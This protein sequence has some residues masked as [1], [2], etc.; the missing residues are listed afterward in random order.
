MACDYSTKFIP[1]INAKAIEYA[2]N[3]AYLKEWFK[4]AFHDGEN[5][6]TRYVSGA[7]F[8]E[9]G[10]SNP[11]RVSNNPY[12]GRFT[13]ETQYDNVSDYYNNA[14][15]LQIKAEQK[16]K[17]EIVKRIIFDI[18]E[19]DAESRWKTPNLIDEETGITE[20]NKSIAKY[21][22]ELCNNLLSECDPESSVEL[23]S[24]LSDSEFTSIIQD[25]LTKYKQYLS[26]NPENA[27]FY[28]DFVTL[29]LFDEMLRTHAPFITPKAEYVNKV[30]NK[31]ISTDSYDK[32]DYHG[33]KVEHYTGYTSSE[34]AAI[35]NQD[36]DLAKL[37]L[38]TIP[39]I[40]E[41]N[42]PI[43][44]SFIG[45]S[46][47][48]ASMTALKNWVLYEAPAEI[49]A[50]Y[51]KGAKADVSKIIDAYLIWNKQLTK[52]IK[53]VY[54]ERSTFLNSKLRS[55]QHY[56]F[57]E[58]SDDL[59]RSMFFGMFFKTEPISYRTYSFNVDTGQ[60]T[61]SNL[62]ST[63]VNAQKFNVEDIVR[64]TAYLTR[65][66][67]T[68]RNNLRAK[69]NV[70]Y[71]KGAMTIS[72]KNDS[73]K[74][75]Q[76]T[77]NKSNN[78]GV[79]GEFLGNASDD[80]KKEVI[81]DFLMFVVPDT[82]RQIG[83]SMESADWDWANDFAPFVGIIAFT[84]EPKISNLAI[85]WGKHNIVDLK[86]YTA[87]TLKVAKKLSVIYGSE[88]R[89]VVKNL[90]GSNLPLYQ[91]T[92]L[93]YNLQSVIDDVI[94]STENSANKSNLL[95]QARELLIAPQVRQEV[96]V[97]NKIKSARELTIKEQL[98]LNV[99]HDFYEAFSSEKDSPAY[100]KVYLQSATYADKSTHYLFGYDLNKDIVVNGEKINL[101][102]II[103]DIINGGSS[104]KLIEITRK[105]RAERI[106]TI[107]SNVL[108]DYNRVYNN[109]F[110][111]IDDVVKFLQTQKYDD[112]KSEF[113]KKGVEFFE[114]IHGTK[115]KYK[116]AP[117]IALNETMMNQYRTYNDSN[118]FKE[119]LDKSKLQFINRID[120]NYWKWNKYDSPIFEKLYGDK[121]F[122]DFIGTNGNI[123]THIGSRLNP[124]LEAY[125][126]TDVL[127]SNEV[128]SLLIGE[129]WAHPNKNKRL[130]LTQEEYNKRKQEDPLFDG[131]VGTYDEFSEANRLIAQIKR[132]VAFGAT[133]HPYIQGLDN[134]VGENIRIAVIED[135][136]GTVFT[137]NG[138]ENFKLDSS[139]GSG[140]AHPL[141][142]RLENN[143][144]IDARVGKNKKSIM[145][146]VDARFGRPTL[147]KWAV[148]ELSNENRRNGILSRANLENVYRKMSDGQF[149]IEPSDLNTWLEDVNLCY[150]DYKTGKYYRIHSFEYLNDDKDD[151]RIVRYK[152]EINPETLE[153]SNVAEQDVIEI[154]T[155]YE[156]DQALGGAWTGE[157]VNG[158]WEYNEAQLDIME[159]MI[160]E[161]YIGKNDFV[162]YL[163]NKSAIKVGSGNV[164]SSNRWNNDE[165]FDTIDMK[166][167]YGGVQMDADHE[168]D[169]AQVTEM[170]QMISAL[171]E[172][173]HYKDLVEN[174][175]R[176]IGGVVA[177]HIAKLD[178]AVKQVLETGSD[179][180][181]LEL[182]KI[183]AKSW[184]GA[185][186]NGN[187]DT[188][189]I[190]QAFV[191]K[192][193]D[194]FRNSD[195]NTRIPF[196]A[197]TINGS[198]VSDVISS[199]NKGGIR[200]K[201]EGY[202]GVLNPSHDM[203]QY[204]KIFRNGRWEVRLFDEFMDWSR[205]Q[206]V[207]FD[208]INDIYDNTLFNTN[209][210]LNPLLKAVNRDQVDFEDT[211]VILDKNGNIV[212]S[213]N[214]LEPQFWYINSFTTYD[215]V[216][217][218]LLRH[219]EYQVYIHTGKPRNLKATNTKFKINGTW[220]SIYDLD[221][222]RAS[223]YLVK[224]IDDFDTLTPERINI[225][226]RAL[227]WRF[228]FDELSQLDDDNRKVAL[229]RLIKRCNN[230]T[231]NI[232]KAIE[233]KQSF[234]A[235]ERFGVSN[236]VTTEDG[237]AIQLNPFTSKLKELGVKKSINVESLLNQLS[238][239]SIIRGHEDI[240]KWVSDFVQGNATL[241]NAPFILPDAIKLRIQKA[242]QINANAVQLINK[243]T[244]FGEDT[245]SEA[246]AARALSLD[247]QNEIIEWICDR[248]FDI[249][250]E[251]NVRKLSNAEQ[252]V[253]LS[254]VADEYNVEA[255]EIIGGRYQF[256]KFGLGENDHIWQI[257]DSGYFYDRLASKY[258]LPEY[259]ESDLFDAILYGNSEQ[260]LVKIGNIPT[261]L[262]GQ[263][264]EST[265]FR[266]V[267]G[268]VY[269]N[270]IK[271]GSSENKKFY[272]YVDETGG[273]HHLILVNT[274]DDLRQIRKSTLFDNVIRYN[275]TPDNMQTLK[276]L[277]FGDDERVK[278][279]I[280]ENQ[281]TF[282]NQN[283]LTL[284]QLITDETWRL[285][286][287]M[288]SQAKDMYDSF[289]KS[290]NYVG[291]RI[292][293]QAMQSFMA[294]NLIAVTKS[295][296]NAVYVPKSQTYLEGSDYDIDKLYILTHSVNQNGLVQTGS[297]IQSKYGLDFISK[298]SR[299]I[300]KTIV[301][302]DNPSLIV[303]SS[304]V[305]KFMNDEL[306]GD[307]LIQLYN[308]ILNS[309]GNIAFEDIDTTG[310]LPRDIA[311]YNSA[312]NQILR[313]V[314]SHSQSILT[315]DTDENYLKNRVVSG[316]YELTTKLQNQLIAQIPVDM[317][318][319]QTAAQQSTLG[320]AELHINS[321]DP[322][323][324]MM[325]QE[326][327]SVG[328][329]VI[330]ISAVSL[331]AFF[332]LYYYYSEL[333]DNL[334]QTCQ[335]SNATDE[336]IM[337]ALQQLVFNHP[338]TGRLTSL[339]NIDIEQVIDVIRGNERFRHLQLPLYATKFENS[340]FTDKQ[341]R[342][343]DL[344]GFCKYLR[345]EVN[346]T[347]AALTD[348]SV[349]SAATDNAKELILA[350]I[351]AT[352]EL[353]D[354]YTYLTAV[355]TPFLDI[356]DYMTSK[357]FGF[358]TIA[359]ESNIFDESSHN[360]KVKKTIDWFLGKD[361]LNG[362]NQDLLKQLLNPRKRW[363]KEELINALKDKTTVLQLITTLQNYLDNPPRFNDESYAALQQYSAELGEN[364]IYYNRY[365]GFEYIPNEEIRALI[366]VLDW[367][368]EK[369]QF[370]EN[371][372]ED[373]EEEL[374]KIKAISD[375]LPNV[376]EMTI[377]GGAQGINQGQRTNLYANRAFIKR[378][379]DH[380]NKTFNEYLQALSE[381]E[382]KRYLEERERV[383]GLDETFDFEQF[384]LDDY[385]RH[386]WIRE[387]DRCKKTF[388]ILEALTTLP[389]FWEM[390]KTTITSKNAIKESSWRSRT[391]WNL[392]DNIETNNIRISEDDWN[393]MNH[394]LDDFL[395]ASFLK[396][397][398][399]KFKIPS[400]ITYYS[401]MS[402][403][404]K[405]VN[406]VDGYEISLDSVLG[407]AS[408]KRFMEDVV[409]P[410]LKRNINYVNNPFIANLIPHASLSNDRIITGWKLPIDMMNVSASPN[411]QLLY[412]NIQSGFDAI[413]N[414]TEFGMKI[415]DLFY[416][417]NLIVNKDGYGRSSFTRLFENTINNQ[418]TNTIAYR[419]NE[420]ISNLDKGIINLNPDKDEVIYRIKKANPDFNAKSNINYRMVLP[421]DFTLDLPNFFGLPKDTS[422]RLSVQESSQYNISLDSTDSIYAIAQAI[423]DRYNGR[424]QIVTDEELKGKS[425]N[426]RNAKAFIENGVVNININ[427]ASGSDAI[428][429]LAHLVL[430][431][432]KFSDNQIV[433]NTYYNLLTTIKELTPTEEFNLIANAYVGED[434]LITSDIIE[435]VL[436]HQFAKY[437]NGE[438]FDYTD[439]FIT[440]DTELQILNAIKDI[441]QLQKVPTLDKIQ[442]KTLTEVMQSLGKAMF[443]V[444]SIDSEFML[445][446]QRVAS[447][448][449]KLY[450]DQ[451]LTCK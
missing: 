225:I 276:R 89:N 439:K 365:F 152:S 30:T 15:D 209:G 266:T 146:D 380:V 170:T 130:S 9:K 94:N 211:L 404:G 419:Y 50:E 13:T 219:P 438:V 104:E 281:T 252:T 372:G 398:G 1:L 35:E 163:V 143:S 49:R 251:H 288:Q 446:T 286:K 285:D 119:R 237:I 349:I 33:P 332:G 333:T 184:I 201:Y 258:T 239:P 160:S 68:H 40:N 235:S 325:M 149:D 224:A 428:H 400:G 295:K 142:S 79:T 334:K 166:S 48:N 357:S 106:N 64:S 442:G 70:S 330:G 345:D 144:L 101:F 339:A 24:N 268:N 95:V 182:Y 392:A 289:K 326:Q 189:G 154:N 405:L 393:V 105:I 147:L 128:N 133:Y 441:L 312:K 373:A 420:F 423:A 321:D 192:A 424:V 406:K 283:E 202:A 42:V 103:Q 200:H 425:P 257:N 301:V 383:T 231:Q 267:D 348:S 240:A 215:T 27:K 98:Q 151:Y 77:L 313:E 150:K 63:F 304:D 353:V 351:N 311:R 213:T 396:E 186:E 378:I 56:L 145:M 294:M 171:I 11:S 156:L 74:Y 220:Y 2:G 227:S 436:A 344:F 375:I 52:S 112:V 390:L 5:I 250:V 168:L 102:D 59:I 10:A 399:F 179:Q 395:I 319:P 236:S 327:N 328:K 255:A 408:F 364:N 355:G 447:M 278:I 19:E 414:Q 431:T 29:S 185:F 403:D 430:A 69:Y 243:N 336:N 233:S 277:K 361:L 429:E 397:S 363:S 39:D 178:S 199:I 247:L 31:T 407:I 411:T 292:P 302:S 248:Y 132:S 134:G 210:G 449:D 205:E 451:K 110:K 38:D 218:L 229:S 65:T 331:K 111:S 342:T 223:Q 115:P 433:R 55:I 246:A 284:D 3:D 279:Y 434:G 391:M 217:S 222:V 190:A 26:T 83:Q 318:D 25:V 374:R 148:Y 181:K 204:F 78:A 444:K 297:G 274:V 137:P 307:D 91:L 275:W 157:F 343:F 350:K 176:D 80:F 118:A 306:K 269:Y 341:S 67:P 379:N 165:A 260:F 161:G 187:K 108:S 85:T 253:S 308:L 96:Q 125:F 347:D 20:V 117:S 92:N 44:G 369:M 81:E 418:D 8:N 188:I 377:M 346:R 4:T 272:T 245:L 394:Y 273:K 175:Y 197:A 46:G 28:S 264:S 180:A 432:M 316:I 73:S 139:D 317:G 129:V 360:R 135:I 384:V 437:L 366:K 329:D 195:F 107:I 153:E 315:A 254:V 261:E 140:I 356:A 173:G 352:P 208:K 193:S 159:Q 445:R 368:L 322:S 409:I 120:S 17:Q 16:F 335:S 21:K 116:G 113:A 183:V 265:D 167:K 114:E 172:D 358:I 136:P 93:S 191:K 417:Y 440:V 287:R 196:S 216:K 12:W 126:Y 41:N 367:E 293:T 51:Y 337:F 421:S 76:V 309:D 7:L 45:L 300:G 138:D 338:I 323:A 362:T 18:S 426:V 385:Y 131:E 124:I 299:P 415:G 256:E 303:S 443:D 174:I 280:G 90:S 71:S 23:N 298:L 212:N 221:S 448:E 402:M 164:N 57:N 259:T 34:F 296:F 61:G 370:I 66:S 54:N 75:L 401:G 22:E 427:S 121:R 60:I 371:L 123:T 162:G 450:K 72:A 435:E 244:Q 262:S 214:K 376:N 47:F 99:L 238:N 82:Y 43:P 291:A 127:L 158:T 206:G 62:R 234:E 203:I 359:G 88:T 155:L 249:E 270:G 109:Q 263:L 58:N 6:Y 230:I 97:G 241:D 320:K 37:L 226:K 324:K 381:N 100:G 122:K 382:R 314:K 340:E 84:M 413:A 53:N 422:R 87:S 305:L 232:L 177:S 282:V 198:F 354:I 86:N 194:A 416:L 242:K 228:D 290:L 207:S 310:L 388:N 387:Y 32:Y 36:S 271:I 169:L 389:H 412:A 410:T 386:E 14:S 141:Q